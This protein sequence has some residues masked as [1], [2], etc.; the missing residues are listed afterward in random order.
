MVVLVLRFTSGFYSVKRGYNL[1][2][3]SLLCVL[4]N[5]LITSEHQ[6]LNENSTNSE[7]KNS[8]RSSTLPVDVVVSERLL[9]IVLVCENL[10]SDWFSVLGLETGNFRFLRIAA[11]SH[12]WPS[13]WLRFIVPS[14]GRLSAP[15][16]VSKE[17]FPVVRL[18]GVGSVYEPRP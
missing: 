2:H 7:H 11:A 12:G 8:S 17:R 15:D 9:T 16:G 14:L 5:R 18:P 1:S 3:I 6:I 13:G 10:V 4:R